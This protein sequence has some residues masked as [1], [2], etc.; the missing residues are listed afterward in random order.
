MTFS[1]LTGFAGKPDLGDVAKR[2]VNKS[3]AAARQAVAR[4][5]V[6]DPGEMGG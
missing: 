6:P 5:D 4:A 3:V 2:D 1:R